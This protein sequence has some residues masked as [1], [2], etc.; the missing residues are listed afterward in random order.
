MHAGP[1]CPSPRCER[2]ARDTRSTDAS[3]KV[4]QM[5]PFVNS[6]NISPFLPPSLLFL[7][8]WEKKGRKKEIY[9]YV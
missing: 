2:A 5:H 3:R 7:Q 4:H 6:N 1:S 8:E 9:I